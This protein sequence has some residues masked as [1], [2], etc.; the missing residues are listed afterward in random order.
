MDQNEERQLVKMKKLGVEDRF[1]FIDKKSGK[2]FDRTEYQAMRRILGKGS[3]VYIDSLDRL[4]RNYDEVIVEWKYITRDLDA[5]I[6][7]LENETLF[8]SRKFKSMGDLGKLL[9][10]QFLSLLSYV[11]DQER[12]RIRRIQKEGIDL[13]KEKGVYKG[14]KPIEVDHML[15]NNLYK[16]WKSK[17]ITAIKF[18]QL[19]DLKPNTFYRR[20]K[21]YEEKG[22]IN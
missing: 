20:I 2:D 14:R 22:S 7:I 19:V 4:G 9:E 6:V 21:T 15:W 5:D 12:Q 13:A 18:M 3:L 11:G 8:D 17:E 10:D 16:Q 1:I